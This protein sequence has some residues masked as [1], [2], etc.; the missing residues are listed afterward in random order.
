[1]PN[2]VAIGQN[3]VHG[4][5]NRPAR[6]RI[7]GLTTNDERIDFTYGAEKYI[8]GGFFCLFCLFFSS[9]FLSALFGYYM[10]KHITDLKIM[11]VGI[12]NSRLGL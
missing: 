2:N 6:G 4:I 5:R 1:M 10:G 7:A 12:I 3:V 11:Y 9:S 8:R